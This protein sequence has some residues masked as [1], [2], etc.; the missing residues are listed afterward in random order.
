MDW[1]AFSYPKCRIPQGQ[2]KRW[3]SNPLSAANPHQHPQ[4]R[5]LTCVP[6]PIL[7]YVVRIW[8]EVCFR[9]NIQWCVIPQTQQWKCW[10]QN[11]EIPFS[12]SFSP[13]LHPHPYLHPHLSTPSLLHTPTQ[14]SRAEN[15]SWTTVFKY[16]LRSIFVSIMHDSSSPTED[17]IQWPAPLIYSRSPTSEHLDAVVNQSW[18]AL[19]A[20]WLMSILVS[21]IYDF[22][23]PTGTIKSHPAAPYPKPPHTPTHVCLS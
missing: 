12:I 20:Y 8:T 22:S 5:I 3:S 14:H 7:I 10:N 23:S 11:I 19:F 17:T 6:W 2:Q 4:T 18:P 16:E 13:T 15:Y 1:S 21:V 9:I